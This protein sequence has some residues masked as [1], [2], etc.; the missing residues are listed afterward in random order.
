MLMAQIPNHLSLQGARE[1]VALVNYVY[2]STQ[3]TGDIRSG[4]KRSTGQG[5]LQTSGLSAN[6]C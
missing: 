1:Y 4:K 2:L 3:Q 5:N 6:I